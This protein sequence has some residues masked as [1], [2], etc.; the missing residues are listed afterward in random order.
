MPFSGRRIGLD[1]QFPAG[2]VQSSPGQ[3]GK[4]SEAGTTVLA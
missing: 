4:S 3:T 1:L 2:P